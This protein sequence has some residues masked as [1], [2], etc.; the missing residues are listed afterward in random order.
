MRQARLE[1]TLKAELHIVWLHSAKEACLQIFEL[2]FDEGREASWRLTNEHIKILAQAFPESEGTLHCL[3]SEEEWGSHSIQHDQQ[4][5]K[6]A[7]MLLTAQEKAQD[8]AWRSLGGM[9]CL[10]WEVP[11]EALSQD[12]FRAAGSLATDGQRIF[13]MD[14]RRNEYG[15]VEFHEIAFIHICLGALR[16]Q[17]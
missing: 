2:V 13:T 12:V 8:K 14:I 1:E 5:V 17:Q 9:D 4:R 10:D 7:L 6:L 15:M 16:Y 11:T 3:R